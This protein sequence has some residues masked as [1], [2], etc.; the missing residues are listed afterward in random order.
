MS[1]DTTKKLPSLPE[2]AQLLDES[3]ETMGKLMAYIEELESE[4]AAYKTRAMR[5]RD[6]LWDALF[7]Q[8]FKPDNFNGAGAVG[9]AADRAC[10]RADI[11]LNHVDGWRGNADV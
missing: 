1:D 7:M 10:A 11:V 5:S 9:M 4:L 3:T 2:M 6:P 8:G